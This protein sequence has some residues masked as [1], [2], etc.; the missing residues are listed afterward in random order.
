MANR[1][2]G[3]PTYLCL[4]IKSMPH[5]SPVL[6]LL[7]RATH[8]LFPTSCR[9]AEPLRNM[10]RVAARVPE[11]GELDAHAKLWRNARQHATRDPRRSK[12]EPIPSSVQ[13]LCMMPDDHRTPWL[14][15]RSEAWTR[16]LKTHELNHQSVIQVQWISC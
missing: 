3:P 10:P 2:S 8:L 16:A 11:T 13:L 14:R 7:A 4:E 9:P 1:S 5:M 6:I 15:D 12:S